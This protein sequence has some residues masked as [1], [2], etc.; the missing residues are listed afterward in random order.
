MLFAVFLTACVF[1]SCSKDDESSDGSSITGKWQLL[2]VTHKE[3]YESCQFE[4]Y[5]EF[6]KDG[7][8]IWKTGCDNGIGSWSK[9]G[10]NLTM[11]AD[12][13]PFPVKVKIIT[14]DKMTLTIEQSVG[15]YKNQ[16]TYKRL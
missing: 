10:D 2:S 9:D 6:K 5:T 4:G 8:W 3:D 12:A 7:T 11:T 15:G 13:F 1:V 14:L 16:E